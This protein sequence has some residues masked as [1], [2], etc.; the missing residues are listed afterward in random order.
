[1]EPMGRGYALHTPFFDWVTIGYPMG[2]H[3]MHPIYRS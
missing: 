3:G 2:V 1:M